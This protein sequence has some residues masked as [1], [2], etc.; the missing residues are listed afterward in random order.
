MCLGV[1]GWVWVGV[2]LSD[3]KGEEVARL[4]VEQR[5]LKMCLPVCAL[6]LLYLLAIFVFK[7]F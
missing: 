2:R 5:W 7:F 6:P 1:F 4:I 3:Q